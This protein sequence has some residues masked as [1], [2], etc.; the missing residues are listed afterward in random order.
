MKEFPLNIP[1]DRFPREP[2]QWRAVSL[3][4]LVHLLL[5]A[6]LWVG[7]QWQNKETMAVEAEVWDM[8]TRDAAPKPVPVETTPE[9]EKMVTPE[10]PVVKVAPLEDPEIAL[11]QEKKRKL[12][13]K[14]KLEDQQKAEREEVKRKQ[15]QELNL[16]KEK[17]KLA[18]QK[19]KVDKL[20]AEEADKKKLADSKKQQN[21]EQIAR[22]K[23]REEDM[24][25]LTGQATATGSGGTGDAAKSTGNNRG[26]PSYAARIGT[27]VRSNTV[28][29]APET[30]GN[31]PTVEYRIELLPDG[32]LR[33]PIRK[34]KSSGIPG[35]DEAVEKA[36][37]KSAPFPRDKSGEVP[38]SIVYVHRMKE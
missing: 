3:A 35:F 32:S 29:N 2:G 30:S 8:T 9:P 18:E 13:E 23:M 4:A 11:A 14:K 20:A 37:E 7:V 28:F 21:K 33:G 36:I 15:E 1:A 38:S 12:A 16:K 5:L 19:K 31:N 25:R 34:L 24:R 26:D 6:F 22:E 17:E 10:K 27:K